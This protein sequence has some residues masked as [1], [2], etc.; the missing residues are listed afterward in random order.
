MHNNF[1]KQLSEYYHQ[2]AQWSS[3]KYMPSFAEH[4]ELSVMSSAYPAL[5]MMA[6]VGVH[7]GAA[8]TVEAFEWLASMPDLVRASGEVARFL[9]DKV[10][11]NG[12]DIP[13]T[14]ECY[15]A[16]HGVGSEAA[17]AAVATLAEHAWRTINQ[18]SIEV[19]H[20]W[21]LATRLVVNLTWVLEVIYHHGQ[22]LYT[23]GTDNKA[24]VTNLFLNPVP[25]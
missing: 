14:V 22:D 4:V 7:D 6:L 5:T 2:E 19:N 3:D 23:F 13:S 1:F 10:K 11:R 16:E 20:A 9:N 21:L 24:V 25:V 12:T 18:A 15:M 17:V 8:A